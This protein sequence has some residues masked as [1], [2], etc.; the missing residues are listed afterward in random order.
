MIQM[1]GH[2]VVLVVDGGGRG[3]KMKPPFSPWRQMAETSIEL[4]ASVPVMVLPGA[5]LFPHALLPL[6]I[7]EPRYREMLA[8]CLQNQRMFCVALMKPGIM[9]ASTSAD[10][11]Q[12]AGC[13]LVRACVGR[14]DGT[15]NL[16]LQ[17][18]RRVRFTGY[19]QEKPFWIAEVEAITSAPGNPVE[20]DALGAKA[21]ELCQRLKERGLQLPGQLDNFLSHL[22]NLDMLADL[23]GHTFISDP[24][25]RQKLLEEP[26]IPARLRLLIKLLAAELK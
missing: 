17:G 10:F 7:F 4:P 13:G 18:L 24:F 19:T 1:P 5:L 16:I 14:E 20:T 23:V 26:L 6:Y 12:V 8:H 9:E 25:Q 2:D 21:L 15:S 3:P 22:T 11:F